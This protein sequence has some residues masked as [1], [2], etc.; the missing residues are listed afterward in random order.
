METLRSSP[1]SLE[2]EKHLWRC[3]P[4]TIRIA[5][6]LSSSRN[7][8]CVEAFWFPFSWSFA[9]TIDD[10][11]YAPASFSKCVTMGRVDKLLL[12]FSS[13]GALV[14]SLL[15]SLAR[16]IASMTY[17][18][19]NSWFL[20]PIARENPFRLLKMLHATLILLCLTFSNNTARELS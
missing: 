19:T 17:E 18:C 3:R 12:E 13:K 5:R 7:S 8:L 1:S 6:F 16:F 2:Y 11:I 10:V 20:A 15:G 14:N 9:K 4:S